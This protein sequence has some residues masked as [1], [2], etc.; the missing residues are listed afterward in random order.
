M[1]AK[2]GKRGATILREKRVPARPRAAC[3]RNHCGRAREWQCT[4]SCQCLALIVCGAAAGGGA[5]GAREG[6]GSAAEIYTERARLGIREGKGG[7]SPVHYAQRVA[8]AGTD[9]ALPSC[10]AGSA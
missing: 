3:V 4:T 5:G 10:D 9:K 7:A 1:R 2:L 8:Q 6:A